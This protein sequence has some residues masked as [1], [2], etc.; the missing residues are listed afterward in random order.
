MS[1]STFNRHREAIEDMFDLCIG[2]C[3]SGR[4]S[5]YYIENKEVLEN[6][7]LQ[8]WMLDSLS[9]GNML[10][11]STSLR[12]RIILEKI[13]AGKHFLPLIID[14]MKQNHKLVLTYQKFEQVEPYSIIVEPYAIK[15]FKQRWYLLAKNYKRPEPTIYAL[16]RVLS[17]EETHERFELPEDFDTELFFKDYYGV[18][19]N[20]GDKTERIVIRAYPR[21]TNYLRTLPRHHS[22][23]ELKGTDGYADFEYFLHPTFDFLQEL[24][25]KGKEVEVLEPASFRQEIIDVL[26]LVMSRHQ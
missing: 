26:K 14:A 6:D 17:I 13:P 4:N 18:L 23:K 2:C 5:C 20:T 24:L 21:L 10:M 7:D 9:I 12:D 1:R 3:K 25:S 11:E 15:V 16:D 19:C 22:Q 8:H